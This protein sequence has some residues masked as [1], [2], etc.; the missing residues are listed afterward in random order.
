MSFGHRS[1]KSLYIVLLSHFIVTMDQKCKDYFYI[2]FKKSELVYKSFYHIV[3]LGG[4]I[5]IIS[6]DAEGFSYEGNILYI[7]ELI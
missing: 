4:N 3:F 6:S 1:I 5:Q 2:C 7:S